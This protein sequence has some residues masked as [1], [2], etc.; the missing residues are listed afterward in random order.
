M[1]HN[2]CYS[3]EK[4]FGSQHLIKHWSSYTLPNFIKFLNPFRLLDIE[5]TY[6]DLLKCIDYDIEMFRKI[7]EIIELQYDIVSGLE[8]KNSPDMAYHNRCLLEEKGEVYQKM[9]LVKKYLLTLE[10][11]KLKLRIKFQWQDDEEGDLKEDEEAEEDVGKDT[12]EEEPKKGEDSKI[13]YIIHNCNDK[14]LY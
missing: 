12:Q 10:N 11:Q 14:Y 8:D 3:D 6:N 1:I 5:L 7:Y 9:V 2:T 13:D 4:I